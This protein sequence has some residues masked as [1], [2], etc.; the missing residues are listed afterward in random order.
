MTNNNKKVFVIELM[1][2]H[3]SE[4]KELAKALDGKVVPKASFINYG[5]GVKIFQSDG[6]YRARFPKKKYVVAFTEC[7]D[8]SCYGNRNSIEEVSK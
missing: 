5:D 2:D 7:F 6:L 8:V 4:I 3:P 1:S